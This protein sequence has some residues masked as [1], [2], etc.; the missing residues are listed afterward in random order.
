MR[1]DGHNGIPRTAGDESVAAIEQEIRRN[2]AEMD[3]TL[4]EL[5]RRLEP[6]RIADNLWGSVRDHIPTGSDAAG[7]VQD[8]GAVIGKRIGAHPIPSAIIGAGILWLLAEE[9][10]GERTR[11]SDIARGLKEGARVAGKGVRKMSE[12]AREQARQRRMASVGYGSETQHV[13][14]D[15][16]QTSRRGTSSGI[17]SKTGDRL[18]NAGEQTKERLSHMGE[19]AHD[20]LS[21]MGERTQERLS[22]VGERMRDRVA[23]ARDRVSHTTERMG[24]A[25]HHTGERVRNVAHD[26]ADKVGEA[27]EEHP[28]A[29]GLAAIGAGLL[30]GVLVPNTRRENEAIGPAARRLRQQAMH[31]VENKMDEAVHAAEQKVDEYSHQ[32]EKKIQE[33]RGKHETGSTEPQPRKGEEKRESRSDSWGSTSQPGREPRGISP[34][35]PSVP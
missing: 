5:S 19:R 23:M 4:E 18:S 31:A 6:R 26:T 30:A 24:G 16:T 1:R 7:K 22:Q 34:S 8:L 25:A 2:R 20:R 14:D 32:A 9:A 12:A 33:T 10:R 3:M 29:I 13:Y 35:P 28:L 11:M 21:H 17:M 27:Y 15:Y